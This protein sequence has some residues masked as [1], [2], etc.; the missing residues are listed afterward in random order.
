MNGVGTY[1]FTDGIKWI[2]N[3]INGKPDGLGEKVFTDGT[4]KQ[5]SFDNMKFKEV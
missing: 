4:T 3:W 5:A 1:T 2:G